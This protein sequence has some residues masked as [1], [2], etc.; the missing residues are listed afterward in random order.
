MGAVEKLR[1]KH[2]Q[3]LGAEFSLWQT[4]RSPLLAPPSS[5]PLSLIKPTLLPSTLSVIRVLVE[6]N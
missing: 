6:S 3:L 1:H 2:G 4:S 5:P